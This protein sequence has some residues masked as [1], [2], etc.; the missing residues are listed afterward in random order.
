[1]LRREIQ[2]AK[3]KLMELPEGAQLLSQLGLTPSPKPTGTAQGSKRAQL[4]PLGRRMKAAGSV[5]AFD[6]GNAIVNLQ[7]TQER[8]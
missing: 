8:P 4:P 7:R 5:K 3:R 6:V 2:N 1:M